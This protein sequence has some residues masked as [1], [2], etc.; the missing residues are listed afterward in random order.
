[1][2]DLILEK[3]KQEKRRRNQIYQSL[4]YLLSHLS[5]FDFFSKDAFQIIL[6]AKQFASFHKKQTITSEIL[7]LGFFG[8]KNELRS[9]LMDFDLDPNTLS[10]LLCQTNAI[11]EQY[12]QI[13]NYIYG[14]DF[15]NEEYKEKI[16]FDSEIKKIFEQAIKNGLSRF[17]TPIISSEILFITMMEDQTINGSKLIKNMIGDETKWYLIR[18]Q[19]I[20]RIHQQE[21]LI[22]GEVSI[23]QHYFAC[24]LKR[25]LNDLELARLI[26][27]QEFAIAVS[28][29][30]NTLV[31]S[32]LAQDIFEN[33]L[34]D[35]NKSIRFRKLRKYSS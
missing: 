27:K 12:S 5:Y 23:N 2:S 29:F 34:K 15:E 11:Y 1:M 13:K 19:L 6:Q 16:G 30:R 31:S 20:K 4:D 14:K 26:E 33:I 8:H 7:L 35:I 21:S 3:I 32:I 10:S 18:Y 17:K 22:R 25:Q 28:L 24:L 9:F